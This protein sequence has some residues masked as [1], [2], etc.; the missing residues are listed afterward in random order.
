GVVEGEHQLPP[1]PFAEWVL[2]DQRL[3]LSNEVATAAESEL[4]VD[5]IFV[6]G[7]SQ[8]F[9]PV[10]LLCGEGLVDQVGE[11][12]PAPEPGRL[13][14]HAGS[15]SPPFSNGLL[16]SSARSGRGRA[17]PGRPPTGNRLCRN[18]R[19]RVRAPFGA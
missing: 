8:L 1:E 4:S 13:A 17:V 9:K 16:Q 3:Q 12:G 10:R 11:G 18:R 15:L 2:C 6:R 5:Q 7:G 14:K 19:R